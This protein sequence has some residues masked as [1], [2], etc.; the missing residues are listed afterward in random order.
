MSPSWLDS[1]IFVP[2]EWLN[3]KQRKISSSPN[4]TECLHSFLNLWS[5]HVPNV[6]VNLTCLLGCLLPFPVL[7]EGYAFVFQFTVHSFKLA[8]HM[9]SCQLWPQSVTCFRTTLSSFLHWDLF[10]FPEQSWQS[11]KIYLIN[12]LYPLLGEAIFEHKDFK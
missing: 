5:S 8:R 1:Y 2:P 10:L 3:R 7:S 6:T 12:T 11:E 9:A 4:C